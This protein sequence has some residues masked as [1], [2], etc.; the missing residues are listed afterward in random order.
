MI[1]AVLAD[2]SGSCPSSIFQ[3]LR[4][5][6]NDLALGDLQTAAEL[7]AKSSTS[8]QHETFTPL[9]NESYNKYVCTRL[10]LL[11]HLSS[12]GLSSLGSC[13]FFTVV[14]ACFAEPNAR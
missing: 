11:A 13:F 12:V 6:V 2:K 8:P 14:F 5:F 9:E 7:F 4:H 3:V 1:V 10:S